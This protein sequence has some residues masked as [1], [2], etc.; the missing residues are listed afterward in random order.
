MKQFNENIENVEINSNYSNK[1][2]SASKIPQLKHQTP[3]ITYQ[4][5]PLSVSKSTQSLFH[6]NQLNELHQTENNEIEINNF[7]EQNELNKLNEC[8]ER[9]ENKDTL[10][11]ELHQY[12]LSNPNDLF[13][14]QIVLSIDDENKSQLSLPEELDINFSD[15]SVEVFPYL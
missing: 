10:S 14:L 5:T 12:L 1:Y 15:D 9:E 7:V 13:R 6:F 2:H 4:Q 8:K 11:D 3:Q